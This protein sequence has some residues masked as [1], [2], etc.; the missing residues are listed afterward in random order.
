MRR[1]ALFLLCSAL[2][3]ASA[4]RAA[5]AAGWRTVQIAATGLYAYRYVP[6]S[7]DP[8]RPAPGVVFLHGYLTPPSHYKPL[9]EP[10]A[11]ATGAIAIL[12]RADGPTWGYAN[13]PLTIAESVRLVGEELPID[14]FRTSIAG[15]SAGGA[16]AYL[17]AYRSVSHYNAVFTL[18]APFY[19]VSQVVDPDYAA[20][21]RMYYGDGDPNYQT[22]YPQLVAQWQALGVP[23]QSQIAP[24]Y[25][26]CCWADSALVAGFQ[27]LVGERYPGGSACVPSATRHCLLG[28]RYAVELDWQTAEATGSGQAVPGTD[29][30]GLFWFFSEDNWEMLVKVLDGCAING[31]HWVFAAATT[32][33]GYTLTVTDTQTGAVWTS[34]NPPGHAAAPVQ[35]TAALACS[36]D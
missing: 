13:D 27:F 25:P 20:P 23:Q 18:S 5:P 2:W 34:E 33:V 26:H 22:A 3:G 19:P 28:G 31:H 14:P 6:A 30:S 24:G 12:P 1:A 16:Y 32:D 9:V 29:A 15:H 36:S 35:D 8:T 21:I 4:A 10:G 7:Y 17:L 11:E